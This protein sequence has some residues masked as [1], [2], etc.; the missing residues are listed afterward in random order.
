ME[1]LLAPV[2]VWLK[3]FAP[4]LLMGTIGAIVHRLRT[5]MSIRQ[6]VASVIIA[7]LVSLSVGVVA[8]EYTILSDNIIFILCGVSGTFS[9]LILDEF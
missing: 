4:F 9:K 1:E 8:Q 6:F 2:V 5:D 3:K 7:V